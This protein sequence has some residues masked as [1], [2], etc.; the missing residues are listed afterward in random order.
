MF[1]QFKNETQEA[2]Y[3]PIGGAPTYMNDL[4]AQTINTS[5]NYWDRYSQT[6][7]TLSDWYQEVSKGTMQ[8]TG[9]AYN[10]ILDN[11][12][13]YYLSLGQINGIREM[14][15]EIIDKLNQVNVNWSEYDNWSGAYGNFNWQEDTRIDMIVKVHRTRSVKGLFYD[16]AA[17]YCMLGP[18]IMG[19]DIVVSRD[20]YI[21]DG[22]GAFG[23]GVTIT[24]TS[25]GPCSK[26]WVFD[27]ARHEIGHYLFGS[28]HMNNGVG[29]MGGGDIYLGAWESAKLGYLYF[30]QIKYTSNYYTLND[31]SSR[32]SY[33]EILQLPIDETLQEYFLIT[34]RQ[35]ISHY[36]RTMLGD[37]TRGMW[38]REVNYGKGIY[39][40]HH[41]HGMEFNEENDLECADGLW[42]WEYAGKTTPDWDNSKTMDV[43]EPVSIPDPLLNEGSGTG[44]NNRDGRGCTYYISSN[45]RE[46]S[47]WFARGKRH[48]NINE[49]GIDRI[50]T[51]NNEFWTARQGAGDRWDAFNVGYNEVFSPYSNP[52]SITWNNTPSNIFVYLESMNGTEATLKIYKV[53][54][55]NMTEAQILQLTPPSR[56]MGIK[57]N[58]TE[59]VDYQQYPVITWNHNKEPD[60]LQGANNAYKRYKIYRA[61]SD[62]NNVPGN[63]QEI[64]DVLISKDDLPS[65]TDYTTIASCEEGGS[66]ANIY[67]LRYRVKAVD[68][69]GWASVFSDF[70]S[71]MTG[72]F[73]SQDGE[74][75]AIKGPMNNDNITPIYYELSQN[76]PNPF[77]PVTKINYAIQKSGLA[78]LKVYDLLGR[79]VAS[80]VNEFKQA[81]YYSL[82]FNAS[83]LS[84]GIYFYKL[85]ANDFTDIKKMVL[86]K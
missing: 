14:N 81:G 47:S 28:D 33:G 9:K 21:N 5:G 85:Q 74:G 25:Q 45:T 70:V 60:M 38:E 50:Y 83:N 71:A 23:S 2:S 73:P 30:N 37:T 13:N 46:S 78:T 52:S 59:C 19:I 15:N 39:I 6:T 51:N 29:I 40:Y 69:T 3:W 49:D 61:T 66:Y 26:D 43:Y 77:N 84:S 62:I 44:N 72:K 20:K 22:W 63:F 34:N 18:D 68:N 64:A 75:D 86:V 12:A 48:L 11:D 58:F 56:P 55:N 36:D 42:N 8:V 35:K 4:V 57:I 65:Y 41:D 10:I 82:D 24:G 1:V 27:V 54:E 67:R 53:G 32:N 16:D 79:E 7:E 17:G 80:L 31:I 76:Y